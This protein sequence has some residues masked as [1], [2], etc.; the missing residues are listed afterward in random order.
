MEVLFAGGD[1]IPCLMQEIGRLR[2]LT[3]RAVGEGS[4]RP[5]DLDEFD[6]T[7]M[8]LF[9]WNRQKAELAGAYRMGFA[10]LMLNREGK[11]GFYTRTLFEYP[12]SFVARI[13]PGIELG[14]SF[15][16][17]DYQRSYLPL[18]LFWRGIGKFLAQKPWYRYLFG[19]V[20]MSSSYH[21]LSRQLLISYLGHHYNSPELGPLVRARN[22]AQK[23]S[24]LDPHVSRL[25]RK[26]GGLDELSDII[27]DLEPDGKGLPV[28]F[29]KYLELGGRMLAF[30]LDPYFSYALDGLILIDLTQA[31]RSLLELYMGK[32]CAAQYFTYHQEVARLGNA[33]SGRQ[34]GHRKSG[35]PEQKAQGLRPA[36]AV[37]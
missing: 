31:N 3:F 33:M 6:K 13:S 19:P 16:C 27:S 24:L 36:I 7:Y 22:P 28:F 12:Q 10:D 15:V 29:R 4:G 30:N 23:G 1:Q 25:N 11:E 8:Q 32:S 9:L 2:E 34:E 17:A 14:R 5:L 21:G 37:P 35:P 26:I 20:S 18:L